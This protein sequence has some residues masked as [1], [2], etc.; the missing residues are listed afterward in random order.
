MIRVLN[1]GGLVT[2]R[3]QFTEFRIVN[4]R[5]GIKCT[6]FSSFIKGRYIRSIFTLQLYTQIQDLWVVYNLYFPWRNHYRIERVKWL[7]LN[8]VCAF[9]YKNSSK[10]VMSDP[11]LHS[12]PENQ[13]SEVA[14]VTELW[15]GYFLSPVSLKILFSSLNYSLTCSCVYSIWVRKS[16]LWQNLIP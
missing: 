4:K 11:T 7:F 3:Y 15:R 5:T 6:L 14:K 9:H 2:R 8:S 16:F 1:N 13:K 10:W 12:W